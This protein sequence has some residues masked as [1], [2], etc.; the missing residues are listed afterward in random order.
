MGIEEFTSWK[1]I[2]SKKQNVAFISYPNL[3][4]LLLPKPPEN[5]TQEQPANIPVNVIRDIADWIK[6]R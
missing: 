3:V 6:K 1:E 5:Q 2:F 4:N